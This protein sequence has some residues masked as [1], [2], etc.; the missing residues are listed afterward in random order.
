MAE[1][2]AEE[3][4]GAEGRSRR[5]PLGARAAGAVSSAALALAA[6]ALALADGTDAK[7]ILDNFKTVF[8]GGLQFLG[9][10]MVIGGI[11][12][13]VVQ[14]RMGEGG[15]GAA[16]ASGIFLIIAGIVIAIVGTASGNLDTSWANQG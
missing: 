2:V 12:T 16:V 13:L 4:S 1:N 6:P 15:G 14:W 10:F 8:S 5:A 3:K 11:I 9:S 7:S